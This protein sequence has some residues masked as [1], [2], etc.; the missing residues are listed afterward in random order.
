MTGKSS[1]AA[2]RKA[3]PKQ[4]YRKPRLTVYGDLRELTLKAGNKGDGGTVPPTKK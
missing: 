1:N 3:G 4:P 2:P